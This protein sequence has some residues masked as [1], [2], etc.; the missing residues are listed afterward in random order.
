M[1]CDTL[2]LKA[3]VTFMFVFLWVASQSCSISRTL[4]MIHPCLTISFHA[5]LKYLLDFKLWL[6]AVP[7]GWFTPIKAISSNWIY[8]STYHLHSSIVLLSSNLSQPRFQVPFL[9]NLHQSWHNLLLSQ[10]FHYRHHHLFHLL[11]S[12]S[13]KIFQLHNN[14]LPLSFCQW[15]QCYGSCWHTWA[16]WC[17]VR[18]EC[19]CCIASWWLKYMRWNFTPNSSS[20]IQPF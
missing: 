10:F 20:I 16:C 6:Q 15:S 7:L 14:F 9:H 17:C 8:Q 19:G 12:F 5:Q 4:G 11:V 13:I 1:V 18:Y 2:S 3:L